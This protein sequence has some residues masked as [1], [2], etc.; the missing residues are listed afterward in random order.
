LR[1]EFA[2]KLEVLGGRV[3]P[4]TRVHQLRVGDY[5]SFKVEAGQTCYVGIWNVTAANVVQLFPNDVERENLL[6]AGQVHTLLGEATRVRART[7]A[8]LEFLHVLA[9]TRPLRP[10]D[11][12]TLRAGPFSVFPSPA[13]SERCRV[14]LRDLELVEAGDAASEVL[15]PLQILDE[16]GK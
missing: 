3:D 13:A 1:R 4:R 2:L 11:A 10:V 15:A 14:Q 12:P 6:R 9:S 16:Q 5:I 7:A 8:G